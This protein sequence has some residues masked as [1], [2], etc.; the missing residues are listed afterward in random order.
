MMSEFLIG[1]ARWFCAPLFGLIFGF[2]AAEQG[3]EDPNNWP[4]YHRTPNGFRYSPL[5]QIDKSNVQRLKIAW[6]HH[7]TDNTNGL[8]VTPIVID[9][10]AY[11]ST[12]FNDVYALDAAS[13]ATIWHYQAEMD[14]VVHEMLLTGVSRGVTVGHGMVFMGTSDGRFIALDQQT[15]EERWSKQIT[16]PRDCN[17][18]SFSSPPQLAG[19]ILF[20]G[21][22]G[23]DFPIAS[24]IYAVYASNGEPAWTFDIIRDHPDS[25]TPEAAKKGGGG[26][27]MP[28]SYDAATDTIYIGTGN[29]APDFDGA[30]RPGDNKYTA[31]L[32][33]L[34]GKTGA[35]K[36]SYQE[37][38]HDVWDFDAAFETLHINKDG[39]EFIVHPNKTGFV[40]VFDKKT[41]APRHYWRLAENITVATGFDLE[42][43]DFIG[44]REPQRGETFVQCPSPNGARGWNHGAYNPKTGLWY[45]NATEMCIRLRPVE[46]DPESVGLMGLYLGTEEMALVA[47]PGQPVSARLDARD[48]LTGKQKWQVD[49]DIPVFSSLLTTGGGLVFNIDSR[50]VLHAYDG[51]EGTD[52]WQMRVGRGSRGGLVSYAV[53]G[54]QYIL[55]TTGLGG[56]GVNVTRSIFPDLGELQGGGLLIAFTLAD[57]VKQ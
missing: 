26:A 47:P 20:G 10:V 21:S 44:R 50:G 15:G 55:V 22:T 56:F 33:A 12:P 17:S 45:I 38:P 53:D 18:C 48:P 29:A 34:T 35:I 37:V 40:F 41:G 13:G 2:A 31:T 46:Q 36:W 30:A 23:G 11:Y 24:K 16:Q 5:E 42:K 49:Y 19:D 7:P 28:G 1:R 54:R 4:Q 8:H 51:D 39:Q 25:W 3:S 43:G 9:G 14:P 52:L 32:L 6:I 57:D 27:W